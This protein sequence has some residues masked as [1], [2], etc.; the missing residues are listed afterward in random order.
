MNFSGRGFPKDVIL[1]CVRWYVAYNLSY[2]NIEEMMM[3]RNVEVDH[4]TL[5]RWVV[6]YA[7]QLEREFNK[8]FKR[9][10][11]ASWK[12]DETY[13]KVKGKWVYLYR[14]VDSDGKTIDVLLTAKRDKKAAL[15]FFKKAIGINGLPKKVNIDKSG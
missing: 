7:P 14:T 13:I 3:E 5:Q 4:S 6:H 11:G 9:K 1:Q 2:R 10:T 12:M 15:R 8:Q